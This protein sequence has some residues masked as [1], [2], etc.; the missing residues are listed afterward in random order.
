[1]AIFDIPHTHIRARVRFLAHRFL[2][3]RSPL[4]S[5]AW[6]EEGLCDV[7]PGFGIGG[8]TRYLKRILRWPPLLYARFDR[9]FLLFEGY[10]ING[11][12]E[13]V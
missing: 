5:D 7:V 11:S 12:S 2:V 4:S 1:M 6:F 9:N 13:F 3:M 8:A 10:V